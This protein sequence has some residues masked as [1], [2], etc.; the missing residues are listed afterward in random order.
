MKNKI[1]HYNNGNIIPETNIKR[2]I[3]AP[4]SIIEDVKFFN[5]EHKNYLR[6]N[7]L[8]FSIVQNIDNIGDSIIGSCEELFKIEG[9][10]VK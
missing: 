5:N 6:D 2:V 10:K 1:A 3:V 7:F 8:L 9:C 4:K